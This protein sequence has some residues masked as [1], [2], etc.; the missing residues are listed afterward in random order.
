MR[1]LLNDTGAGPGPGS[2]ID[3]ATSQGRLAL[4]SLYLTPGTEPWLRSNMV[5]TLDGAARGSD[6]RSGSINTSADVAVF[7]SLRAWS[8]AV[9][10]GAAT[11]RIEGYGPVRTADEWA[12][13]RG[14]RP[15]HPTLVVVSGRAQVPAAL[16][17][18]SIEAHGGPVL[19][20]TTRAAGPDRLARARATLGVDG[21]LIA[22]GDRV[23]PAR[24]VAELTDRGYHRLLC[25]GGPHLLG[26]VVA[27][28]ALDEWCETLVPRL[29]GGDAPRILAG[30][31]VPARLAD[32]RPVLLL[33]A[34]GALIGRWVPSVAARWGDSQPASRS[35]CASR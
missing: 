1:V 32:L 15:P 21:V 20:A 12:P 10:A 27:A 23:D 9:I 8:D 31:G 4:Q 24:L 7:A 16:L 22:G 19:L 3:L 14:L 28:G 34:D 13:A 29:A 6:G 30:G 2:V 5:S 26:D 18:G 35:T 11:V 25:E 33:E 17:D